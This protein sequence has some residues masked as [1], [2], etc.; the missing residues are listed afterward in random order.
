MSKEKKGFIVYDDTQEVVS[1]L[2]D[3]EAGKLF[4][5]MLGY[6]VDG[7]APKFRGCSCC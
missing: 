4:K 3:E 5:G 1:R 7:K 2:S 6:S